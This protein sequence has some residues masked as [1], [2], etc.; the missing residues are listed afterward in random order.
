MKSRGSFGILLFTFIPFA[1]LG[2]AAGRYFVAYQESVRANDMLVRSSLEAH[3]KAIV[4]SQVQIGALLAA[5]QTV[6]EE[7][8]AEAAKRLV[9][10]EENKAAQSKLSQLEQT[11]EKNTLPKT[12]AIISQWRP[13]IAAVY[14]EW[15]TKNNTQPTKS[16][17]AVLLSDSTRIIPSAIT[18]KHLL[19]YDSA[20]PEKCSLDFPDQ[21]GDIDISPINFTLATSKYDWARIAVPTPPPYVTILANTPALRCSNPPAIGDSVVILGYPK[22]GTKADIT[23]TEGIISGTDGNY[24]I[25]SAKVERGN[26]GGAAILVKDNCYLGIPTFVDA[27]EIESLAR[28]LKHQQID[29]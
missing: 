27:G 13:R 19:Q 6:A 26:S 3:E 8:K 12:S 2:L 18:S 14:C 21:T 11:I 28:I 23:A 9:A 20:L 24:Y 1:I 10:E 29:N 25:T 5:N 17:T 16:G 4:E 15:P 7:L 22:I